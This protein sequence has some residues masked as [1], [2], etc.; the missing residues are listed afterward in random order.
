[1]KIKKKKKLTICSAFQQQKHNLVNIQ[2]L[3]ISPYLYVF[4][5]QKFLKTLFCNKQSINFFNMVI[6]IIKKTHIESQKLI[7][8]FVYNLLQQ[9]W[10]CVYCALLLFRQPCQL[11]YI[12]FSYKN[13]LNIITIKGKICHN[14]LVS[15]QLNNLHILNFNIWK[16][17]LKWLQCKVHAWYSGFLNW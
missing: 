7:D 5:W 17:K 16:I 1:M 2:K 8:S 15:L 13:P 12:F 9:K 6:M 4:F 3:S 14:N 10:L 11:L